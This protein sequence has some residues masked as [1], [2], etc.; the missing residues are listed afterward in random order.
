MRTSERRSVCAIKDASRIRLT[1]PSK[2]LFSFLIFNSATPI[3]SFLIILAARFLLSI[4]FKYYMHLLRRGRR[5][6]RKKEDITEI[7]YR[8]TYLCRNIYKYNKTCIRS[9]TPSRLNLTLYPP[10]TKTS[11][12]P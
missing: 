7:I 8:S 12:D 6:I 4:P 5:L 10:L 9:A 3:S 11:A 2:S 1:R